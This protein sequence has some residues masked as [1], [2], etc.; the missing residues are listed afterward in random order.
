VFK[1]IKPSEAKATAAHAV[2]A[3][4]WTPSADDANAGRQPGFGMTV[5]IVNGGLECNWGVDYRVQDRIG[6]YDRFCSALGVSQGSA[7]DCYSMRPY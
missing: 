3:G 2:M 5:N 1:T 6:F 7:V 4:L